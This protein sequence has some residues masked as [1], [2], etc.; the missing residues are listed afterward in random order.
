MNKPS[1]TL[2][3]NEWIGVAQ[4]D[5]YGRHLVAK[6]N[7]PA[8]TLLFNDDPIV[9]VLQDSTLKSH[10]SYCFKCKPVKACSSCRV[11]AYCSRGC[12]SRDWGIHKLECKGF[13]KCPKI[14]G[15]VVRSLC[16]LIYK[17]IPPYLF[18]CLVTNR[19]KYTQD[20]L[21]EFGI[22]YII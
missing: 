1:D 5:T 13:K 11:V 21:V 20:Q 9:A 3:N 15:P 12:Q 16:R 17:G 4:D 8:S 6:K 14:P 22:I 2:K 10:C 18:E 7:I 19:D